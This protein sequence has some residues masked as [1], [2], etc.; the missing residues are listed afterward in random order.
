M[1]SDIGAP[2]R[3][4]ALAWSSRRESRRDSAAQATGAPF[5]HGERRSRM[6][7]PSQTRAGAESPRRRLDITGATSHAPCNDARTW[8]VA[9]TAHTARNAIFAA[10]NMPA[11]PCTHAPTRQ[12]A[13][14][15]L[16]QMATG[17]AVHVRLNVRARCRHAAAEKRYS[18][19]PGQSATGRADRAQRN[20][21][22]ASYAPCLSCKNKWSATRRAREVDTGWRRLDTT[23][24]SPSRHA[25]LSRRGAGA[26]STP[27]CHQ[28]CLA[29][30]PCRL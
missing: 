9:A 26:F 29:T 27:L 16:Y 15:C 18:Q 12:R 3:R 25:E 7:L 24:T 11:A 21:L 2:P 20:M 8:Q 6:S 30:T 1:T 5:R 14:A 10:R 4:R 23:L 13:N 17:V 28:C 22:E 19:Q